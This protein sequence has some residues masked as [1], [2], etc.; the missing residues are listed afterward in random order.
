MSSTEHKSRE[1]SIIYTFMV[2]IVISLFLIIVRLILITSIIKR[3]DR[4]FLTNLYKLKKKKT[5]PYWSS[6]LAWS[7]QVPK[8]PPI[9]RLKL[10]A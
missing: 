5:Y 4:K 8:D 1:M 6:N 3:R 10:A 2:Y 9:P 7:C